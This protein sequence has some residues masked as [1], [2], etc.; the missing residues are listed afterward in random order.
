M[1]QRRQDRKWRIQI[2][3]VFQEED[4]WYVDENY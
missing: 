3:A 1:P 2:S 4:R